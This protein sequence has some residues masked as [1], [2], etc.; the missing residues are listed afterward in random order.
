MGYE[1]KFKESE[2]RMKLL[3]T[4][5]ALLFLSTSATAQE[6]N[7]IMPIEP[8][9][10]I[11]QAPP[12]LATPW[13]T[14]NRQITCNAQGL[15]RDILETS[16]QTMYASGFKRPEY[17]PSDPFDGIIITRNEI[18]LEYTVLLIKSDLNIACVLAG[19]ERFEL[20]E[21]TD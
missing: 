19:G 6:V 17:I 1:F 21:N 9:P 3:Y 7:P 16:G 10:E 8:A 2:E 5:G 14:L 12:P 11:Q 15:V 4:L 18:T 13:R 20:I